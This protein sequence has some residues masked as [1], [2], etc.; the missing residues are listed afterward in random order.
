VIGQ[1]ISQYR[2]IEKLGGGG[3]G[4]GTDLIRCCWLLN[5]ADLWQIIVG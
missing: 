3:M 1:A 4:V 5:R 2:I